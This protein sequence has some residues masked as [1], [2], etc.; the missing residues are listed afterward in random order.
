LEKKRN[1]PVSS[2]R[3]LLHHTDHDR[4]EDCTLLLSNKRRS[5]KNVVKGKTLAS[6][7][8]LECFMCINL[9]LALNCL[10]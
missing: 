4:E 5:G 2:K 3:L 1:L 9:S 8:K 6:W 10:N 7:F